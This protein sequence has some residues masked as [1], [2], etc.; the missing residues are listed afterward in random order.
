MGEPMLFPMLVV[1]A[2]IHYRAAH[3][4]PIPQ[5][6]S[7]TEYNKAD[8]KGFAAPNS[9][10]LPHN[11]YPSKLKSVV[12]SHYASLPSVSFDAH[13]SQ[14]FLSRYPAN[15]TALYVEPREGVTFMVPLLLHMIQVVPPDWRFVFFGSQATVDNVRASGTAAMHEQLG[16]LHVRNLEEQWGAGWGRMG[17]DEKGQMSMD[18]MKNRLLT[19][20][21]FYERELAG[22]EWLLTFGSDAV[23]CSNSNASVDDWLGWDFVGAP[24][25]NG[26][27]FGGNGGLSLRRLSRVREVLEFQRRIDDTTAEDYWM[28]ARL[29]LLPDANMCPPGKER[30]FAVDEI[31]HEWPMGFHINPS[32]FSEAVWRRPDQRR[33]IYDYC[34]EIKIILDMYLDR[35]KCPQ[36]IDE[37]RKILDDVRKE[38]EE[39]L[40]APE[41]AAQEA[42][43]QAEDLERQRVQKE[44]E[45]AEEKR[46]LEEA[47]VAKAKEELKAE[48]KAEEEARKKVEE[49]DA[50]KKAEEDAK[51][52]GES[53][54]KG[55]SKS[56]EQ[57][58]ANSDS[59]STG[60]TSSATGK[61]PSSGD[62]H[63]K[64]AAGGSAQI[65]SSSKDMEAAGEMIDDHDRQGGFAQIESADSVDHSAVLEEGDS[66]I[67][68]DPD[69][70]DIGAPFVQEG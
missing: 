51:K 21:T 43:K 25:G 16:K 28:S 63:D 50:K 56:T 44:F 37:E 47:A 15:K 19:N 8:H 54:V 64:A 66:P 24:W 38:E 2:V 7:S 40:M 67:A 35:E 12:A 4:S 32:R 65:D 11:P 69:G 58:N 23:L 1:L 29:A 68:L 14:T 6:S 9:W 61:D 60:S 48:M 33:K 13:P 42:K 20:L 30:E 36:Q 59:Q 49:E 27:R 17:W 46:K 22:T 5:N 3:D 70:I 31:Y 26:E 57:E 39:K 45:E 18:E 55:A 52:A 10:L 41:I 53:E 34:P 62:D